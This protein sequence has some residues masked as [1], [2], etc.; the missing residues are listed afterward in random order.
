MQELQIDIIDLQPNKVSHKILQ[1]VFLIMNND[2]HETWITWIKCAL[3]CCS[4]LLKSVWIQSG[5]QLHLYNR[6][7]NTGL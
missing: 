3:S 7:C 1:F 4:N 2:K 5:K 6:L